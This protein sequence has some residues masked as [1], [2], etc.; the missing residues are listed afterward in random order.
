MAFRMV[1]SF[2]S[3]AA[4]ELDDNCSPCCS[5]TKSLRDEG[6][7]DTGKMLNQLHGSIAS[8]LG[9][10]RRAAKRRS[11][12]TEE[13]NVGKHV[14]ILLV[15]R[16]SRGV[17]TSNHNMAPHVLAQTCKRR[18]RDEAPS[19]SD[20]MSGAREISFSKSRINRICRQS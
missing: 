1:A 12:L 4:Y 3:P 15:P 9:F 7:E 13:A 14:S 10:A 8:A 18:K 6:G 11:H 17:S 19:I 5:R 2:S 20:G 16:I